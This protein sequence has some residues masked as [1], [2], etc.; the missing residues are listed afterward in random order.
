MCR[1]N[2]LPG[3]CGPC[4]LIQ[5]SCCWLKPQVV[6]SYRSAWPSSKSPQIINAGE[7][8][9]TNNKCG[10]KATF[11]DHWWEG[12]LVQHYGEQYG[13]S[14]KTKNRV[15]MGF[16]SPTPEHIRENS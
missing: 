9:S 15:I 5:R 2:H 3:K 6:T 14:L 10:E 12:K 8:E 13:G 4:C 1:H 7:R 11:L 16:N